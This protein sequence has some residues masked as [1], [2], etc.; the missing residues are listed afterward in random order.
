M[1]CPTLNQLPPAPPDKI[2]WPWTEECSRLPEVMSDGSPWPRISIVT[3]S[4]NQGSFIE[5]TIRSVLLQGYPNL[6]YIVIDGGSNDGTVEIIKKYERWLDFWISEKDDG[7]ADAI[8]KGLDRATGEVAN[9]LNSDDLLYLGALRRVAM[10][11]ASDKTAALYNGPALRIDAHGAYG[12]PFIATHLSAEAALEGTIP[13]PQP[14]IFFQRKYWLKHGKIRTRL[15]YAM[16]TDLFLH[17]LI[18]GHCRLISGPPLAL[19]RVHPNMKCAGTAA[20]R[21]MFLERYEI[22]SELRAS[23]A[24]PR[25]LKRPIEYGLNRESLRLARIVLQE[26]GAWSLALVWFLRGLRYSPKRTLW[27]LPDLMLG[28]F[29]K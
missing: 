7:Q 17:C 10:A 15:Y 19:M 18:C 8:N 12:S 24:T 2:G 26:K 4:Y 25:H 27:R 28:N 16:D 29:H 13:L 3:P 6:E 23:P 21:P 22:F 14:A 11:Y 9:W 20:L 1:Q 5:E